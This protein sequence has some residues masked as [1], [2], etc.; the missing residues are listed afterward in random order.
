MSLTDRQKKIISIL[1]VSHEPVS[2]SE[3][4]KRL[5]VSRQIIVQDIR[6]LK[7]EG[8]DIL[9]TPRGYALSTP[10]SVPAVFKV[11]HKEKDTKKELNLMVDLGA[12][13]VDV[14]IYHRVYGEM[15]AK[16]EIQSRKDVDDFCRNIESGMSAPLS[17][18]T[19][20]YHYHTI[21]T[22]DQETMDMLENTLREH[23]FLAELTEHE[24]EGVIGK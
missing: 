2:G 8:Y 18:A 12:R 9:S 16:L 6:G 24:P 19:A 4:S 13:V 23:G 20:G 21:V 1:R 22:K 17:S 7:N 15:H 10:G 14:F 5:G 3:M 11:W